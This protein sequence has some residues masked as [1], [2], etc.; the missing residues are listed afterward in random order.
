LHK[1]HLTEHQLGTARGV[2]FHRERNEIEGHNSPPGC[3]HDEKPRV[4]GQKARENAQQRKPKNDLAGKAGDTYGGHSKVQ[5]PIGLVMLDC[6][7]TLMGGNSYGGQRRSVEI[8]VEST[9]RFRS[10]S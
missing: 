10:G 1:A 3:C 9:S 8:A 7:A 2:E 4:G 6:V 5:R